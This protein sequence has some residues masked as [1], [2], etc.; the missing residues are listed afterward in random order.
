MRVCDL[1]QEKI[2]SLKN[3]VEKYVNHKF[4]FK[5]IKH[6]FLFYI[7]HKLFSNSY[8]CKYSLLL[9]NK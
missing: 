3:E 5:N 4:P 7:I 6:T 2:Q 9:I 8:N 1:K